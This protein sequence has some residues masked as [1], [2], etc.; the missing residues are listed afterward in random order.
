MTNGSVTE[1]TQL[2]TTSPS[3]I[4]RACGSCG[5]SEERQSCLKCVKCDTFFHYT[6]TKIPPYELVKYI[7]KQY[8]R[9][10]ICRQCTLSIHPN[11]FNTITDNMQTFDGQ[12]LLLDDYKKQLSIALRSKEDLMIATATYEKKLTEHEDTIRQLQT[13]LQQAEQDSK[14]EED[15]RE[16]MKQ[17]EDGDLVEEIKSIK[18]AICELNDRVNQT[19]RQQYQEQQQPR[20]Y[21]K[22]SPTCYSC[23]RSGHIAR[24]CRD[25][26]TNRPPRTQ[27]YRHNNY[28]RSHYNNQQYY[29]RNNRPYNSQQHHNNGQQSN[30]QF[31]QHLNLKPTSNS[32]PTQHYIPSP[33]N[34]WFQPHTLM[35]SIT[36]YF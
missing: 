27:T 31:R 34:H 4:L 29:Y 26:R 21:Y 17:T 15:R 16:E 13:K 35:P 1:D 9:K 36:P 32:H 6:C 2:P 14:K 11:E 10:Y 8:K 23:G 20:L 3:V 7:K 12:E 19:H 28:N 5:E 18:R 30:A 24:N 33:T 25:N 22:A